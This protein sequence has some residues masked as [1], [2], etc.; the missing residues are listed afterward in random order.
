MF[1]HLFLH[2]RLLT[3]WE[4]CMSFSIHC[5]GLS[6]FPIEWVAHIFAC[7][8]KMTAKYVYAQLS[9]CIHFDYCVHSCLQI[10]LHLVLLLLVSSPKATDDHLKTAVKLPHVELHGFF[11]FAFL[12]LMA[13]LRSCLTNNR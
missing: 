7:L 4:L 11:L 8:N 2:K 6:V 13:Q 12:L 5:P 1:C 9:T 3:G 10:C